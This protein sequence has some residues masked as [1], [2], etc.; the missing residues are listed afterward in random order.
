MI[1][2]PLE[3][4]PT[5]FTPAWGVGKRTE[6]VLQKMGIQRVG[7]LGAFPPT[8]IEKTLG[9]FGLELMALAR[10]EDDRP[11]VPQSEP[12]SISQEETFTPDLFDGE[13]MHRVILD[14][15]ERVGWELRKQKLRG[16]TVTLKVRY[17]DFSL[18]TRS[19]T[20]PQATDQGIEIYRT[21]LQLLTRTEALRKKARLLGVG[22][23]NLRHRD[24]PEQLP[25][26]DVVAV[27]EAQLHQVAAH[28]C[29][30]VHLAHRVGSPGKILVAG[31]LFF[32][33]NGDLDHGQ[34]RRGQRRRELDRER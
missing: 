23:S 15:A 7:Q 32:Q 3:V 18:V 26:F 21:A 30:D 8:S 13:K 4:Q 2:I 19:F 11:V 1:R 12:K 29:A 10:G 24:D 20:L 17:P 31:N 22:V 34:M 16:S 9:R 5:L 28:P 33:G 14:Q 27:V 6:E 25:L